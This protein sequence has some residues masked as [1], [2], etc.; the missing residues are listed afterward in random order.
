VNSDGETKRVPPI[1]DE[2]LRAIMLGISF[3]VLLTAAPWRAVQ[4]DQEDCNQN[5]VQQA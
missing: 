2:T 3:E 4:K 1:K 5:D